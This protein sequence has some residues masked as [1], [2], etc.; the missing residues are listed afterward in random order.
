[1]W[2]AV[3]VVAT[4]WALGQS[5]QPAFDVASVKAT[6]A[7]RQNRLRTDYCTTG[8]R[9]LS[10]GT[11]LMW[12][13]GYA[14]GLRDYQ[15]GNAP[16][17]MNEFSSAYDIEAKPAEPVNREQCRLMLQSLF[18]DRF[19]LKVHREMKEESVYFLA[20]AKNGPKL[21][22]G[23]PAKFGGALEVNDDG[24]PA[25]PNGWTM[26]QLAN[27]I[28]DRVD[29]AV[30]DHTGLTGSYGVDLTFSRNNDADGLPDILTA[31]QEQLGLKLESGKAPIEIL[32]I[33]HI[34]KPSAN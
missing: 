10:E 5:A 31:V 15:I 13:L 24:K 34:E 4:I 17:W 28:A 14:F 16:N 3:F 1:M 22:E 21:H 25:W 29:K 33:D 8:G 6:P 30:I 11:P 32:V 7:E 20:I 18:A 9:F 12:P 27:R 23:G 26:Q 2:R 19:K